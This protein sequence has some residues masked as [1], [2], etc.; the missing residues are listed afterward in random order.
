MYTQRVQHALLWH[1]VKKSTCWLFRFYAVTDLE[2]LE[3][4]QDM[5]HLQGHDLHL[6]YEVVL[7]LECG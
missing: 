5:A 4:K 1:T 2:Y 6:V 7:T 3:G